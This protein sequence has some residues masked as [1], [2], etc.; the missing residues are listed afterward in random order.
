MLSN[1]GHIS[2]PWTCFLVFAWFLSFPTKSNRECTVNRIWLRLTSQKNFCFRLFHNCVCI[3][4]L[5]TN[6]KESILCLF[7][8]LKLEGLLSCHRQDKFCQIVMRPIAWVAFLKPCFLLSIF[9]CHQEQ[10]N[11]ALLFSCLQTFF[12]FA[13]WRPSPVTDGQLILELKLQDVTKH[14]TFPI[15]HQQFSRLPGFWFVG[16]QLSMSLLWLHPSVSQ[17]TKSRKKWQ[18]KQ[19]YLQCKCLLVKSQTNLW[20]MSCLSS[21]HQW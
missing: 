7:F 14:R 2:S 4:S 15:V 21:W 9:P 19:A 6:L 12:Q 8:S 11:N 17:N 18:E 20:Q 10:W 3:F 13:A 5:Q 16:L 1:R